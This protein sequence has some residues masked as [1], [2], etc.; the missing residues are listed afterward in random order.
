MKKIFTVLFLLWGQLAIAQVDT[1]RYE[2]PG[3][4]NID[5]DKPYVIL[6]S[7]DGFRPDYIERHGAENLKRLAEKGVFSK[8][9]VPSYPTNT[10]PNHFSIV[11]GMYP[12]NH[13]LVDN[14][15]YD[16]KRDQSYSM[17]TASTVRD[18]SWY[19]GLPLW[20][21]AERNGVVSM[22]L[23][24]VASESRTN[25]IPPT[26]YYHY[27]NEF[28]NDR[29]I[30]IV[31]EMLSL[32]DDVRPHLITM[33]FPEVDS[34]GHYYG[35]FSKETKEAVKNVDG[36]IQK[37]CEEVDKLGLKN[38]NYVLVSDH[39]M[40]EADV[41]HLIPIPEVVRNRKYVVINSFSMARIHVLNKDQIKSTYKALKKEKNPNFKVVLTKR[42]PKRLHFRTN[43]D[44]RLGDI[45]LLP[46]P[47]KAFASNPPSPRKY[48]GIHG[49]DVKWAPEMHATF[50]AW[51]PAFKQ[52]Y[53]IGSFENVHVYPLIADILGLK[54][55]HKIDGKK[56]VLEKIKAGN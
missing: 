52:N 19:G 22:S 21:L 15:F 54:Y 33:Y 27:H 28:S 34:Q 18:S 32:P 50:M 6:I 30:E 29:K 37:L 47:P 11:T 40:A 45:I 23:F 49:Y 46:Y 51:G 17:Y 4:K 26:Y 8:G 10:F 7:L 2:V 36:A 44:G 12:S 16:A 31:K 38:V 55:D 1:N 53:S 14:F 24:W 3:R 39:G 41:D 48:P 20:S 5:P 35:P 25:G 43:E 42:M 9:M 13:G 56:K